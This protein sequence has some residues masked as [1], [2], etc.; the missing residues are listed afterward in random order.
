MGGLHLLTAKYSELA[1]KLDALD[2]ETRAVRAA[3]AHLHASILL[4]Q[5]DYDITAIK[6]K[7][8]GYVRNPYFEKGGYGRVA[9]EILRE[10]GGQLCAREVCVLALKR[11]GLENPDK[12]T[13]DKM[14]RA[15]ETCLS[16]KATKGKL[17]VHREFFPKRFSI[18]S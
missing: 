7:K 14:I 9:M 1:G 15:M 3:M 4:I 16:K 10:N 2:R 11:Q 18:A 5:G 12:E 17:A 13:V 6:P 8:H